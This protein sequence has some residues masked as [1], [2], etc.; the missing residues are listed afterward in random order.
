MEIPTVSI[1]DP[2]ALPPWGG[3][4]MGAVRLLKQ[5]TFP[6]HWRR[7]V[8]NATRRDHFERWLAHTLRLSNGHLWPS[9]DAKHRRWFG[10]SVEVMHELTHADLLLLLR[11]Q[12]P[13]NGGIEFDKNLESP[14]R[15]LST[16]THRDLFRKEDGSA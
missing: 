7:T 4:Y 11:I 2:K 1:H 13:D 14:K 15:S 16:S 9:Y 12:H 10:E 6:P 8:D 5:V 3:L